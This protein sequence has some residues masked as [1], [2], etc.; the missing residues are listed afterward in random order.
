VVGDVVFRVQVDN[1]GD[2]LDCSFS[3]YCL[4][5]GAKVLQILQDDDVLV[6]EKR[7]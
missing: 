5:V 1:F 6:V 4:I 3:D 2:G 7:T